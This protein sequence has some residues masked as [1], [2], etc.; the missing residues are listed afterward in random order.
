MQYINIEFISDIYKLASLAKKYYFFNAIYGSFDLSL[1]EKIENNHTNLINKLPIKLIESIK[2]LIN[3]FRSIEVDNLLF[4]PNNNSF[5]KS[6]NFTFVSKKLLQDNYIYK[7]FIPGTNIR[8]L[9]KDGEKYINTMM[10][11]IFKIVYN[12]KYGIEIVWPLTSFDIEI[13]EST[14]KAYELVNLVPPI[15]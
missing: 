13:S 4:G 12:R 8:F 1:A 9:L 2:N 10:K 11:D 15:K 7:L 3:T 14:K 6:F 5:D